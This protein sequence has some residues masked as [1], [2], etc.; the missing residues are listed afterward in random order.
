[1][2]SERELS[3]CRERLDLLS[4]SNL[5]CESLRREAIGYLRRTIGFDRWCWPLA[6]PENALAV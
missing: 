3:R 5:D 6:D 1:M 4:E 2:A